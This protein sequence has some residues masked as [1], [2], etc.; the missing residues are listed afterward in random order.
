MRSSW[1]SR[2][3]SLRPIAV[4]LIAMAI[5]TGCGPTPPV[6]RATVAGSPP[7]P[8]RSP[9]ADTPA[10]AASSEPSV[11]PSSAWSPAGGDRPGRLLLLSGRTGTMHLE[12]VGADG[13]GRTIPSLEPDVA[14]ISTSLDGRALATTLDGRAYVSGPVEGDAD[15]AWRTMASGPDRRTL[16]G[17]LAF[18]TLSPDGTR[19]AF[20]AADYGGGGP[21]DIVILPVPPSTTHPLVTRVDLGAE[22][23]PPSWLDGRIVVLARTSADTIGAFLI[24]P[25]A[26]GRVARIERASGDP[27]GPIAGLSIAADGRTVAVGSRDGRF[28]VDSAQPWVTDVAAGTTMAT[29]APVGLEPGPDGSRSFAWLALAPDGERIAIVRTDADGASVGVTI[30]DR[31]DGWRQK[32]SIPLAPGADRA[33]VAWL[34]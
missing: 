3:R 18:G 7:G 33:V 27:P 20:V 15:P 10:E 14:W 22:G 29:P 4:T 8:A 23:A 32:R 16:A 12:V 13:D 30:H 2:G 6:P 25:A 34:P 17:P 26:P 31:A 28:V 5:G 21:F 24:D 9:A 1:R 19:A 11:A